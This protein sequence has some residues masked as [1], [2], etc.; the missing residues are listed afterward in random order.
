MGLDAV[1]QEI[2][3]EAER[4]AGNIIS[5]AEDTKEEILEEAR[6]ETEQILEEAEAEA[7]ETAE[8]LRKKEISGARM[9]AKEKR[10]A[11]REDV[12]EQA[13]DRFRER[14]DDLDEDTEQELVEAALERLQDQVDIGT[15]RARE[16][17]EDVAADYGTFEAHD[18]RGVVVETADGSRRFD[19]TFDTVAE[20]TIDASRKEVSE[21]LFG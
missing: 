1:K 13:F 8:A 5:D 20:R 10:L 12:L 2:K 7:R 9:E 18:D 16:A 4:E 11:A 21:V 14:V 19:L 6:E 15:V 17:L 3:D